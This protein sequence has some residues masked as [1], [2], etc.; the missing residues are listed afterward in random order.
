MSNSTA[1]NSPTAESAQG[2]NTF[3]EPCSNNPDQPLGNES[4]LAES[5]FSQDPQP[6]KQIK[7]NEVFKYIIYLY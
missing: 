2:S 6:G 1:K 5:N 7:M 4:E 3:I